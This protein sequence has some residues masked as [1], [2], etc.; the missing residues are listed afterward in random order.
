MNL[1]HRILASIDIA[2]QNRRVRRMWRRW[3]ARG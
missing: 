3:D 2:L 1:V